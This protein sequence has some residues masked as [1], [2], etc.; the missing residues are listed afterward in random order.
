MK[1]KD[2]PKKLPGVTHKISTG[3][4]NLYVTVNKHGDDVFEVF[5]KL[6]KAGGCSACT[7]EALT[8]SIS[9]GLRAGVDLSEYQQTLENIGCIAP[10]FSDGTKINSCPDAI[11]K[12]LKLYIKEDA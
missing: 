11:A 12:V 6:G 2:R 5:A 10:T 3:C 9:L 1:P 8:R 7:T 4:G